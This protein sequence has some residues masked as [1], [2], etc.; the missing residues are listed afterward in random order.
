[1]KI[2]EY[3]KSAGFTQKQ[4]SELFNPPIP[5]DTVKKWDSGKMTPPDWV[6]G[7]IIEKT[8]DIKMIKK[9]ETEIAAN[10]PQKWKF[11]TSKLDKK[12]I[13]EI[14]HSITEGSKYDVFEE[15]GLEKEGKELELWEKCVDFLMR[16]ASKEMWKEFTKEQV[17]SLLK[18]MFDMGAISVVL[19]DGASYT[20][21]E[22]KNM[23]D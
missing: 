17:N 23:E 16:K 6:E 1:M 14:I 13:E 9:T 21:E 19:A 18:S 2:K 12:C 5:I 15:F 8:E 22:I 4:F 11:I 10:S 7:L 3:R 20:A